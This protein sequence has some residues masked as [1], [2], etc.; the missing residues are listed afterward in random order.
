MADYKKLTKPIAR[1]M[2]NCGYEVKLLPC[3]VN[4]TIALDP[5]AQGHFW[6]NPA[7]IKQDS[8]TPVQLEDKSFKLCADTTFDR[9]VNA[10]TY[11][12]CCAELGYYPHY[13]VTQ[14]DYDEW[15]VKYQFN[16]EDK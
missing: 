11:Y 13:F 2:Y 12:N 16:K 3:K 8:T 10:Y 4:S 9:L 6:I 5:T 15:C 1:K 7:S 14:E